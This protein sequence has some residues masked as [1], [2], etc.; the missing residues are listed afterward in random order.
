MKSEK[1]K[2]TISE[3]IVVEEEGVW[4]KRNCERL[5]VDELKFLYQKYI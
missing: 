2:N 4:A 1:K 3:S 5:G